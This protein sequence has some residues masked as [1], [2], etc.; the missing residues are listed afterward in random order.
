MTKELDAQIASPRTYA[1][2]TEMDALFRR[3]RQEDPV[4]WTEPEGYRPFWTV[5]RHAD[6]MEVER[7]P[8]VF[9]SA[10]RT[11]LR[12]IEEEERIRKVTGSV[13]V[14]RTIIQMDEPDHRAYRKLTEAWFM[15][16]RLKSMEEGMKRLASTYVERMKRHGNSCDF[17]KDIAVWY[18][19]RAVMMLLGVPEEDEGMI[20]R[21]TQQHFANTDPTVKQSGA[22]DGATTATE[23]FAYFTD[24]TAERRKNPKD[25]LVSLLA[26]AKVDGKPI[27]DFDRNSYF[28][29]MA[30]AGHDTTSAS[31][32]GTMHALIE[33]PEQLAKLRANPELLGP[34]MDEGIRW[35]SPVRHFFR[36]AQMDYE[37]AGRQIKAGDSLLL[38]YPSANRDEAV[39]DAPYEFRVDR[40]PNRHIAFG[41]GI[42]VCLGQHLARLEMKS[43]FSQLLETVDDLALAG[44]PQ[45]L[46]ANFVGGLK[47]LPISY[48]IRSPEFA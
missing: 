20:L 46:E 28:F 10:P 12:S 48:R 16:Q 6:I 25:D 36:T 18:P 23:I 2:L 44:E 42:H 33:N 4:H 3:L 26:D 1:H 40:T 43:L 35:T 24:L 37:L 14:A 38:A 39:F 31:I 5:S 30:L 29:I 22:R 34:A 47:S 9:I 8:E 41:F 11:A 32:G 45:W 21:L 7:K 19:L 15:P 27:S 17:V 13:Q